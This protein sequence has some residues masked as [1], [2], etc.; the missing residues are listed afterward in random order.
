MLATSS[1]TDNRSM[2]TR[3]HNNGIP[4][5]TNHI[6]TACLSQQ[7]HRNIISPSDNEQQQCL[8]DIERQIL[9]EMSHPRS[10]T[11]YS[12]DSNRDVM[13]DTIMASSSSVDQDT[14]TSLM[15]THLQMNNR[16]FLANNNRKIVQKI[17]AS[18]KS[19]THEE[20]MMM[21]ERGI[22]SRGGVRRM[23]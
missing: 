6:R 11:N 3:C 4:G 19:K 23:L 18:S 12:G 16:R 8:N 20:I 10:S 13:N 14:A 22:C 7:Q 1:L 5:T 17:L 2:V 21:A 15:D 9:L